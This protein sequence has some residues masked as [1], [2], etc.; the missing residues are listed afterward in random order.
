MAISNIDDLEQ[1]LTSLA[2]RWASD[3]DI[4]AAWLHGSR[5]RGDARPDSD[6]DLAV[7]LRLGMTDSERWTKRLEL[8][9]VAASALGTDAVDLILME[10]APAPVAH[11]VVRDGRLIVDRD[12]HRRV[13]VVEDVLRRYL[14]EA[15]LRRALDEG[16][17]SRLEE[18]RFAR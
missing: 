7:I 10:D 6:V 14:D 9:D 16:L 17:R 15:W 3:V 8:L 12:A 4:A 2:R 13:A 5:G 11:R 1:R 18:G